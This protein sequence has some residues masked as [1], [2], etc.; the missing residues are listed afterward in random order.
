MIF[1]AP[2][3]CKEWK[4]KPT[5][6]VST[7]NVSRTESDS[8]HQKHCFEQLLQA[9]QG[10]SSTTS[11]SITQTSTTRSSA[12]SLA[13]I[14]PL[15][16]DFSESEGEKSNKCA[17]ENLPLK[18]YLESATIIAFNEVLLERCISNS[19]LKWRL[20]FNHKFLDLFL[21]IKSNKISPY[22]NEETRK[23]QHQYQMYQ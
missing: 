12:L 5:E 15:K 21:S 9:T 7:K 1:Y 17:I 2:P 4:R 14:N 8:K 23:E 19:H 6:H 22:V 11:L 16:N 18:F 10:S 13:L 3:L 20:D